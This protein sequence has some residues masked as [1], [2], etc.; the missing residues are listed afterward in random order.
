MESG[1][2]EFRVE[3][4]EFRVKNLEFRVEKF[5][6]RVKNFEFRVKKFEFWVT[7]F[8]FG[9][10][11]FEFIVKT[12]SFELRTSSFELKSGER[13]K[14]VVR[15]R[16]INHEATLR[17]PIQSSKRLNENTTSIHAVSHRWNAGILSNFNINKEV[18]TWLLCTFHFPLSCTNLSPLN[19]YSQLWCNLSTYQVWEMGKQISR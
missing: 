17:Y 18:G 5:E 16:Y 7:K 13:R 12:S 6:V 8:E 11:S 9:V 1:K 2:I 19:T 10:N 4:V 14:K 15:Q 3:N